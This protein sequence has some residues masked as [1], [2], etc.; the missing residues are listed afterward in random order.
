MSSALFSI[1]PHGVTPTVFLFLRSWPPN[2]FTASPTYLDT[3]W[4]PGKKRKHSTINID[5][6]NFLLLSL[7][8]LHSVSHGCWISYA[9]G[10][11]GHSKAARNSCWHTCL[12]AVLHLPVLMP[13]VRIHAPVLSAAVRSPLLKA[14]FTLG[15]RV[16]FFEPPW[17]VRSSLGLSI[18]H[19]LSIS[20]SSSSGFESTATRTY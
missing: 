3:P 18:C 10:T 2:I 6:I 5:K 19:S 7:V 4:E 16:K 12:A 1:T 8:V 11:R 17:T 13:S 14:S 9:M 20:W 15:D